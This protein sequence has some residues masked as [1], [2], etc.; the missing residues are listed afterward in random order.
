MRFD[1]HRRFGVEIE[2]C[3]LSFGD[4]G[5]ALEDVG[6]D[7]QDVGYTHERT[8]YWKVMDD[9]S[10]NARNDDGFELVSPVLRGT[11]GL[12]E[13]A[14]AV[15]ALDEAGAYVNRTCGLHIHH[16]AGDLTPLGIRTVPHQ[17]YEYYPAFAGMFSL[18][19]RDN[20][21][22]SLLNPLYLREPSI[23][24]DPQGAN[25][26]VAV[27]IAAIEKHGTIEFRQHQAT[28][29]FAKIEAWLVFTQQFMNMAA[30]KKARLQGHVDKT[31]K[32]KWGL[33]TWLDLNKSAVPV[34]ASCR[35]MLK[36]MR[37]K[38]NWNFDKTL[39]KRG[40]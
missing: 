33:F 27:N 14:T 1:Q 28:L 26:Y 3:G 5:R 16:D 37:A 35:K 34:D 40:Q 15:R 11:E 20:D 36:A 17:Y 30:S 2:A 38:T 10:I 21:T 32:S 7:C 19:R 25:R 23:H 31:R 4:V 12:A 13:I 18:S 22:C 39:A 29:S 9:S 8:R 6:L 24:S